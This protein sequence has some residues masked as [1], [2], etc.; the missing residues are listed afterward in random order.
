MALNPCKECGKDISSTA[1]KCPHCGAQNNTAMKR[2]CLV[3][4]GIFAFLFVALFLIM[5]S[6]NKK[7]QDTGEKKVTK[8]KRNQGL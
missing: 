2:G 3:L 6:G 4:V 5:N 7:R 8:K 1:A